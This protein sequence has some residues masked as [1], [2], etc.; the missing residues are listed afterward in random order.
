M[1]TR[2]VKKRQ[3]AIGR[4]PLFE[5][6]QTVH[7]KFPQEL[8]DG[9]DAWVEELQATVPGGA[10]INRSALIRDLLERALREHEA[11]KKKR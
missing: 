5:N 6:P 8:L 4:P 2:K 7:M 3:P 1:S 10:S 11:S 9:L